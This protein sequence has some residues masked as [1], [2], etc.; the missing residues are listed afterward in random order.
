MSISYLVE[1]LVDIFLMVISDVILIYTCTRSLC[2]GG[3]EC[4]FLNSSAAVQVDAFLPV[5]VR[6]R[7]TQK[8]HVETR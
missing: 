6:K 5:H 8:G 2:K 4:F 3:A 7:T 1:T